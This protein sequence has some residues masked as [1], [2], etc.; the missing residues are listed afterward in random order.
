MS[1][2]NSF[3]KYKDV[4]RFLV[5]LNTANCIRFDPPMESIRVVSGLVEDKTPKRPLY[6]FEQAY[7]LEDKLWLSVDGYHRKVGP[8]DPDFIDILT[9]F[10]EALSKRNDFKRFMQFPGVR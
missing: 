3:Q 4:K 8:R 5:W 2:S 10:Y 9:S 7:L 1:Q 6:V